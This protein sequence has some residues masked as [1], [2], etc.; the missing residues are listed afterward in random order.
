[1]P[2]EFVDA[3]PSVSTRPAEGGDSTS[4]TESAPEPQTILIHVLHDGFTAHGKV[5]FRGQEIEY[6]TTDQ[7]YLDTLD[8]FGESWLNSDASEQMQR[9]G[10]VLFGVGPWPGRVYEE[11]K[12]R[13]EEAKRGRKPPVLG[14]V[15]PGRR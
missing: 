9:W 7:A 4:V 1:M 5:W 6:S 2:V 8:R 3:P 14:A 11:A 10:R 12:A 13:E 15:A